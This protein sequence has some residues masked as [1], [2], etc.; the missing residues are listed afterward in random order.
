MVKRSKNEP[1]SDIHR[2]IEKMCETLPKRFIYVTS[3]MDYLSA[4]INSQAC[5]LCV[6]KGLQLEVPARASDQGIDG[7][8]YP[9]CLYGQWLG[10]MAMDRRIPPFF[11]TFRERQMINENGRNL[12]RQTYDEL[13]GSRWGFNGSASRLSLKSKLFVTQFKERITEFDDLITNNIIFRT[14]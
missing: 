13:Y 3:R 1:T 8:T 10:A 12:R 5:A 11:Y 2:S 7:R 14:G 9:Y 4:H 6:E